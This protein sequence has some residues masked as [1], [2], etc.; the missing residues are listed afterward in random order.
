M[1]ECFH[2]H[3]SY[4]VTLLGAGGKGNMFFTIMTGVLALK[5]NHAKSRLAEGYE[6]SYEGYE[7]SYST[8]LIS[9]LGKG[10]SM[11]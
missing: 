5:G 3:T 10:I 6:I 9:S 4:T 1:C 2:F 11:H 8:Y 7:I